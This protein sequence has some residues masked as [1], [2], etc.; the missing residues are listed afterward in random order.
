MSEL[1][2]GWDLVTFAEIATHHS[3]NSKLIKGR[4]SPVPGEGKFPAF[5][6]SGQDVWTKEFEHEGDAIIVSAVGA[7]CG[8]AFLASGK[9]S[10]IANTHVVWPGPMVDIRF[11]FFCLNDESFWDKSGAAQ[12]FVKVRSTFERPFPLPPLPE[13]RRIVAKI[14]GLTAKS[15]RLDSEIA[16]I[17]R[18]VEKYK[19]AILSAAFRGDLTSEWRGD[20]EH[21]RS[22]SLNELEALRKSAWQAL[23][24]GGRPRQHYSPAIPIDWQPDID[25]PGSWIWASIDQISY[26]IQYG[27]SAKA[28]E[29]VQG[30]AVLRMGNIQ[31]GK[32]DLSSLKYLPK[33]HDEF[34]GLLLEKG[35]V[36]FNR[37]NSAELVGKSAVYLDEPKKAS[38]ASYLIRIRCSGLLPELLSG[39]I[40][41]SYGREWVAS[42]V[43]QQVGQANVNGTKLRQLAIPVMPNDEQ[44]EIVQRINSAFAWIDRLAT[45]A[46]SARKLIDHLDHAILAKAFRG[47]LVPQDPNDEPASVLLEGIRSARSS[48]SVEEKRKKFRR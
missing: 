25:L 5:S 40:N 20:R 3:G 19:Q 34:P 9:W 30:V 43:S 15:N 48:I 12:P 29:D 42:V 28:T 38:L 45:Q 35:D 18:L 8:K 10:A 7:R 47:E 41:S 22:T 2:Q 24:S 39:Y 46:I 11:L 14:D 21:S 4:L 33:D 1:P 32:L 31:D 44:V 26:L 37:T 16:R 27:T 13:Q 23:R 6:A 36:L 17:P